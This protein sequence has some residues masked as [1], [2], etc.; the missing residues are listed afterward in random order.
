MFSVIMLWAASIDGHLS[1]LVACRCTYL[2][3]FN[4]F[5]HLV[6][7]LSVSLSLSIFSV[8]I[9]ICDRKYKMG[10]WKSHENDDA[11]FC[12]TITAETVAYCYSAHQIHWKKGDVGPSTFNFQDTRI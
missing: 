7:K 8:S 1:S 6:N 9:S 4:M 2:Y 5:V 3:L 12:G 11:R 10:N